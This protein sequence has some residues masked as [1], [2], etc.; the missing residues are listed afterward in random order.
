M[1][2]F[3]STHYDDKDVFE[4]IVY[5]LDQT[6]IYDVWNRKYFA[7]KEEARQF[8]KKHKDK[9][10]KPKPY[11]VQIIACKSTFRDDVETE[12][13]TYNYKTIYDRNRY[14]KLIKY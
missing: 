9:K 11:I 14:R 12:N 3:T 5:W 6:F 1:I 4:Y 2:D 8:A 7:K 13:C 10:I